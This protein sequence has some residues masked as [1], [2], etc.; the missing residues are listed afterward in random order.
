MRFHRRR[1]RRC[2]SPISFVYQ[3]CLREQFFASQQRN[4][5]YAKKEIKTNYT[6]FYT[7]NIDTRLD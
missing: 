2:L 1:R 7:N 6:P 5:K 4:K 3:L